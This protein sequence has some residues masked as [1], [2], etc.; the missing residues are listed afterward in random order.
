[1]R[2][3]AG[4]LHFYTPEVRNPGEDPLPYVKSSRK[5]RILL[6]IALFHGGI[7]LLPLLFMLLKDSFKKP[8]LYV[9]RVPVVESIPGE[10]SP[11]PSRHRKK[12]QGIPDKGPPSLDLPPLPEIVK[13]RPPKKI[14]PPPAPPQK[15]PEKQVVRPEPEKVSG[16][17]PPVKRIVRKQ[18]RTPR[19]IKISTKRVRRPINTA[20]TRHRISLQ[21]ARRRAQAAAQEQRRREA[22]ARTLRSMGGVPSSRGTPGGGAR[23]SRGVASPEVMHYYGVVDSY[24]RRRWNQPRALQ[25]GAVSPRVIVRFRVNKAGRILLVRIEERS[26]IRAMDLSVEQLI[27]TLN[28]TLPAPPSPME[29]TVTLEIDN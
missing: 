17:K 21:E 29:F 5:G 26:G 20:Q 10:V 28:N 19:E 27:R 16:K 2:S 24:L 13:L 9:M 11:H 1:M 15:V 4:R 6:V 23:V 22:L 12:A 14:D 8:P 3:P 7:L 18:V 25:T